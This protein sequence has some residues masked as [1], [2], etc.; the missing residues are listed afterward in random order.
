MHAVTDARSS[1]LSSWWAA[2]R[3]K[4]LS[5]S[6]APVLAGTVWAWSTAGM[7][8]VSA[9]FLAVLA[10]ACIQ[11]GTNLWNDALDFEH[12]VDGAV[13]LGPR[14]ATAAG[15]LEARSVRRA[16]LAAFAVAAC[17]GL[18]LVALG[19]AV[20]LAIGVAA[21]GAGL[22]YSAG[23]RPIAGTPFGEVFVLAFF[24][25][26][27]VLGTALVHGAVVDA[28]AVVVGT[29]VG[30]PA[31]AVLLVNNHRDR[32]SDGRC[33]RRTLAILI[34]PRP[35]GHLYTLLLLLAAAGPW[36]LRPGCAVAVVGSVLLA[37]A[38]VALGG[39]LCRAAIDR[40]LNR[41]LE[42]T[43]R[44]QLLVVVVVAGALLACG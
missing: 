34:G 43:A 41:V 3:P 36:A 28:E 20:I 26:A 44:F 10:A 16:S 22:L 5:I 39:I 25:V 12:G 11:A 35:T 30:L 29:V 24:G 23:P 8:S 19:G 42:L 4:T 2:L 33:G 31:A 38:A 14:R 6:I 1:T 17:A 13:R 18:G 21:I 32:V 37:V 40:G 9:L 15:L 7:F 27:G